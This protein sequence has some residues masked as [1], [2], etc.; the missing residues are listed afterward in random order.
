MTLPFF[1]RKKNWVAGELPSFDLALASN[2][3]RKVPMVWDQSAPDKF[4][5]P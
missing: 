1:I 3:L 5:R 4:Q 2:P